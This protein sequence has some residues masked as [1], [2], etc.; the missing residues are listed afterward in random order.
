MAKTVYARAVGGNWVDHATWSTSDNGGADTTDPV[1][2]DTAILNA[3][4]GQVTVSSV[5]ACAILTMTNYASTLTI[6]GP[7]TLTTTGNVIIGGAT[8]GTGTLYCN[9]TANFTSGG[10]H[11]QFALRFAGTSIT[12]TLLDDV[13]CDGLLLMSGT[14]LVTIDG[15]SIT[16]TAG[17]THSN[18]I[19]GGT[20]DI[21]ITGGT[22]T[23]AATYAL[24]NDLTFAGDVILSAVLK[25]DTGTMTRSSGTITTTGNTLTIHMSVTLDTAGIT[26]AA[27]T[28]TNAT[29]TCTLASAL[30]CSGLLTLSY[31][32][33]FSGDF[34]ITCGSCTCGNYTI[35]TV[36][37]VTVTGLLTLGTTVLTGAFNWSCGG[38]TTASG[39]VSGTGTIIITGGTFTPSTGE[40][41]IDIT[42]A[43][44]ITVAANMLWGAASKTLKYQSGTINVSA[45]TLTIVQTSCTIDTAPMAWGTV[46]F[47]LAATTTLTI[48]S[49]LS[50][51]TLTLYTSASYVFTGTAGFTVGTFTQSAAIT[52]PRTITLQAG[53]TYTVTTALSL[54]G[55]SSN[56]TYTLASSHAVTRAI[57]TVNPAATS[58]LKFMLATRI[59]SSLGQTCFSQI[60]AQTECF[61]WANTVVHGCAIPTAGGETLTVAGIT[62][63]AAGVALGSCNCYLFKDDGVNVPTFVAYQLSNADTGAYSFTVFPGST[64]FVVAF[65]AGATPVMDV[66][67]RTLVAV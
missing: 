57:F 52:N 27:I 48:N 55:G 3:H 1:A 25:Y 49:L 31:T 53:I 15:Y 34:H 65:K 8:A 36:H 59:D 35:T 56:D 54:V 41:R 10:V 24:K 33:T 16:A 45:R 13:V 28:M 20:T 63:T 51:T 39:N 40:L 47:N 38:L 23:G 7:Q 19:C 64:Y 60:G 61:N 18:C 11:L 42:F 17:I 43:G 2:D 62:K 4:S 12:H 67:D 26:W 9:G 58:S 14:T 6:T 30:T 29:Q 44:D 37:D 5:C 22:L 66:T 46:T 21:T 50:A 32:V